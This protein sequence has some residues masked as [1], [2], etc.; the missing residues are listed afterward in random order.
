V[1]A[2]AAP[3]RPFAGYGPPQKKIAKTRIVLEQ[4]VL[5]QL[6]PG[7]VPVIINLMNGAMAAASY[8]E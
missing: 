4:L 8:V 6:V 7:F 3:L 2:A 1:T 5:E